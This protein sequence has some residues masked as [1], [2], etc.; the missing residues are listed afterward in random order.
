[1]TFTSITSSSLASFAM[2]YTVFKTLGNRYRRFRSKEVLKTLF[3]PKFVIDTIN[4]GNRTEWSPIWFVIIR[5][6]NKI[7]REAGVR[8]L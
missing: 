1:M 5:V 7:D 8:F 2:F 4:N 3:I 6:I